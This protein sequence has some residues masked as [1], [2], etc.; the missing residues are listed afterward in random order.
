MVLEH[1]LRHAAGDH[2]VETGIFIAASQE[3]PER[4]IENFGAPNIQMLDD[5]WRKRPI[6]QRRA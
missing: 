3:Y 5:S 4:R 2:I 6:A 1:A